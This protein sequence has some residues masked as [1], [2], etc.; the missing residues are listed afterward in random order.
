MTVLSEA[1][2][3]TPTAGS[4][5][6]LL[7]VLR[8]V[9]ILGTLGT[10]IWIFTDPRG[11]A[12]ALVPP[13]GAGVVEVLLRMLS[14]GKFL[15][16]LTLLFGVGLELQ[17]RS[18]VRRG[19]R[20]PGWYLWR[21]VLLLAEGALHYLLIFEWDVLMAYALVSL[22]V[23]GM[24]G[25]SDRA[26]RACMAVAAILH[27]AMIGLL[28][29]AGVGTT[30]V[31]PGGADL[32][33]TGSY[34]EQVAARIDGL[35]LY[36]SESVLIIP[37]TVLLFLAGSRLMRAGVFEAGPAG[38]VLRRRLALLG[39]GAGLP[40]NLLT[41]FAGPRWY[42]VDRYLC[43]P[44]VAIGLMA[45]VTG[46]LLRTT[47]GAGRRRLA[48]VGRTA[49]SCYVLQNL[50]CAVLCYG[51]GLGLA[52][53][54]DGL[55]PWWPPVAWVVVSATLIVTAGWWLRRFDRGPLEIAWHW[56]WQLP[57]RGPRRRRPA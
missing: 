44:L 49:L 11:P 13:G 53:R 1:A 41:S 19:R 34:P 48:G 7:D 3:T 20:W 31:T 57:Q 9:A 39:L 30:A 51:W 32:Y 29:A 43:G 38:R 37:L 35:G 26:V 55:R 33:R 6:Q 5:I 50:I 54:L 42:F 23:A 22:L 40:L 46:L 8:G 52:A 15:A 47:G 10:N 18:A 2:G 36:R 25:R 56:A 45:V 12:G 17:Y 27:V 24:V 21:A 28:T 14:N 4:R 16:L